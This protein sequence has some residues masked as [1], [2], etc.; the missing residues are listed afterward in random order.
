MQLYKGRPA[1]GVR[2]LHR[3]AAR[4][5]V[6]KAELPASELPSSALLQRLG[7]VLNP[8]DA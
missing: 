5:T 6:F 1:N 7:L 3:L 2:N 4:G 8:A